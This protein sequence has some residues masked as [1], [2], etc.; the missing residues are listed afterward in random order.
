M[1][2]DEIRKLEQEIKRADARHWLLLV[3]AAQKDIQR[4]REDH[5]SKLASP[6]TAHAG[7]LR[8]SLH[9]KTSGLLLR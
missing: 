2:V 4:Y 9:R 1:G 5:V 6:E 3:S 7:R 8:H